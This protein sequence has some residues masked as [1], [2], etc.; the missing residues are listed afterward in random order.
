ML[1]H[2]EGRGDKW[3]YGIESQKKIYERTGAAFVLDHI[4][5]G[6]LLSRLLNYVKSL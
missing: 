6:R 3:E 4:M 5:I 2:H 1:T